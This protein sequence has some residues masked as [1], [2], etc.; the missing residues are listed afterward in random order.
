MVPVFMWSTT[1]ERFS[2]GLGG[3]AAEKGCR[4]IPRCVI[5]RLPGVCLQQHDGP[6]LHTLQW[7]TG[8]N[9]NVENRVFP[10]DEK[11]HCREVDIQILKG[12]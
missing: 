2:R 10:H 6:K 7:N 3:R 5:V 9:I 12:T 4:T 11:P 1:F 8:G